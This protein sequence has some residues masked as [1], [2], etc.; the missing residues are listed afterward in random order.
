MSIP[1]CSEALRH[2]RVYQ[3]TQGLV[4]RDVLEAFDLAVYSLLSLHRN[5]ST[6]QCNPTYETLARELNV[7]RSTIKR[8]IRRLRAAKAIETR[9]AGFKRSNLYLLRDY[10]SAK[11]SPEIPRGVTD[12]P[13]KKELSKE[14]SG[15]PSIGPPSLPPM[16]GRQTKTQREVTQEPSEQLKACNQ[17]DG[18]HAIPPQVRFTERCFD[19]GMS[20][21]DIK[22]LGT[23]G[24]HYGEV[25]Y[26]TK[27]EWRGDGP[28]RRAFGRSGSTRSSCPRTSSGSRRSVIRSRMAA[29]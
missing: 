3:W 26:L 5:D 11:G 4:E 18:I 15:E 28:T 25:L 22:I 1:S 20:V 12:D 7:S 16:D 2:G 17:N 19:C 6:G 10:P 8:S 9:N 23:L 24:V 13:Q 14:R 27:A 29:R 21:E